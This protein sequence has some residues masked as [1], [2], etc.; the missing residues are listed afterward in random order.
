MFK[1]SPQEIRMVVAQAQLM[2]RVGD[3]QSALRLLSVIDAKSPAAFVKAQ[4]VMA[5]IYLQQQGDKQGYVRCYERLNDIA[6]SLHTT[7]LLADS[8][9]KIQEP[10]KAIE[11]YRKALQ[12]SPGEQMVAKRIGQALIVTH[13][14]AKA[15]EYY[16]SAAKSDPTNLALA[17][18]LAEMYS[19][20]KRVSDAERVIKQVIDRSK[21]F[22]SV[23]DL[24]SL[25]KFYMLLARIQESL[26]LPDRIGDIL[27]KA[28]EAQATVIARAKTDQPDLLAPAKATAASIAFRLAEH[29]TQRSTQP[30]AAEAQ[31]QL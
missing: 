3:T 23:G 13:E 14:Y 8:Y 12:Q 5:K 6:P 28:R 26:K 22:L 16:E 4:T 29:Y 30:G 19:K 1:G 24:A 18:D 20:M 9:M 17:Y 21:E 2:I 11:L 31:Q 25:T 27:F 15:I 10:E 7:L